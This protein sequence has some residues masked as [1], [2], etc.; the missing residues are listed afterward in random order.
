MNRRRL[1]G[2]AAALGLVL[3]LAACGARGDDG[4]GFLAE[5]EQ[6]RTLSLPFDEHTLSPFEMRTLRYAEDLL[7]RECMRENGMDWQVVPAPEEEGIDSAHRRRYGVIETG[8]AELYGYQAPP[9]SEHEERVERVREERQS[10]PVTEYRAAHGDE[11]RT[12]CLRQAQQEMSAEVP[13]TDDSLLNSYISTG[14]DTSLRDPAVVDAF[15]AWSACMADR[16]FAYSTPT[17]ASQDPR[18][19]D[20]V[21]SA[22]ETAVA[23]ADVACKE[24]ASVVRVW[25]GAEAAAQND[26]IEEH[27]GDFA[28]FAQAKKVRMDRARALVERLA[29]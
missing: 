25:H 16:G 2:A 4:N 26:L 29:P 20:N 9:A 28:L 22:E 23:S 15:A 10:L 14:F 7:V 17:E 18:W 27:A 19:Q 12:G 24:T 21:A 8:V 3:G 13:A 1:P 5:E 6:A 11:S